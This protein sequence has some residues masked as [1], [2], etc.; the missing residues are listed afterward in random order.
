MS[1]C[2]TVRPAR[3]DELDKVG[4]LTLEAYLADGMVSA[5]GPYAAELADAAWRA[6]DAELLVAADPEGA[7]L[8]TV[9]VCPPGSRLREISQPGELEFRMLAVAPQVRGRGVG[10][11][12]VSAV[13]ARAAELDA[14][15]VV[16]SSAEGMYAAHRLYTRLGFTRLPGR[17]WSPVPG[18]RLLV[19]GHAR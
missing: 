11:A 7:L 18:L 5:G 15:R 4:R 17:D 6:R 1:D 19:F 3:C 9:T 12:L 2:L 13:L 14:H 8:G 16:L 10:A